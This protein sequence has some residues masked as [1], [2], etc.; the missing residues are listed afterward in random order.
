M[1]LLATTVDADEHLISA[2][3]PE[4]L[5]RLPATLLGLDRAGLGEALRRV[6]LRAATSEELLRAHSAAHLEN[7]ERAVQNGGGWIDADTQVVAGSWRTA[8]LASGAGLVVV[9]ALDEDRRGAT[10]ELV[11]GL[12]VVRPPG[13]HATRSQAMGF[14]L[15]NNIAVT[16][17]ALAERGERVLIFDWDVHHGNGTQAIFWDDPRVLFVSTHLSGHYPFTGFVE[18]SGGPNAPG[19]TINVP[20]PRGATGDVILRL[21]DDVVA[22]ASVAHGTTWVLV[23]AGF[24]S[25][26]DDPLGGLA[27]SAGDF[28]LMATRLAELASGGGRIVLFLEGGYNLDALG[29][30]MAASVGALL[31][32][33]VAEEPA[34]GA[35]PG[36]D[37]IDRIVEARRA[38][39]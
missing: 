31:G 20:L 4:A 34:T 5:G 11:G 23:S 17:A 8:L 16:A 39:V 38:F 12:V 14:C 15:V 37:V 36:S 25:H 22:P 21:I 1:L 9:E 35:G 18:E 27:L 7:M 28:A 32:Q 24:D 30:S 29:H 13:H 19:G 33:P 10:P 2:R 26:R 6:E 3:H